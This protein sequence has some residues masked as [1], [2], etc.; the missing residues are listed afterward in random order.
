MRGALL[1]AAAVAVSL[2]VAGTAKA[3]TVEAQSKISAVTV[4][5]DGALIVRN[6][7]VKLASGPGTIVLTGIPAEAVD[8]SIRLS[9][10][11]PSK[12]RFFGIRVKRAFTPEAVEARTKEILAKIEEQ[13]A[14]RDDFKDKV[15]ARTAELDILK[16]L[17]KESARTQAMTGNVAGVAEG[18]KNVG[19]R[20]A[21]LLAESRKDTREMKK[22]EERIAALRQELAQVGTGSRERKAA[23]ADLELA[24]GGTVA[25]E[26]T[27]M[28]AGAGWSPVYDLKVIT[29]GKK[30]KVTLAFGAQVRQRSGEDWDGVKMTISTAKPAESGRIPDP[31]EWWIDFMPAPR[32]LYRAQRAGKMSLAMPSAAPMAMDEAEAPREA[33]EMEQAQTVRSEYA[34]SFEIV[35]AAMIPSD[36]NLHRVSIAEDTYD[37]ALSLVCVPRMAQ[38]AFIE[39]RVEYGGEQPLLPGPANVFQGD[40]FVGAIQMDPVAPGENFQIGLGKDQNV[41]VERKL[42]TQK[43]AGGGLLG[44]TKA[45]RRYNWLTTI[46]SFHE[47]TRMIEVREQLPRSRQKDIVVE[48]LDLTPDP[49]AESATQPGLKRWKLEIPS[50]GTAK[51]TFAYLVK[52]PEGSRIIGL[53]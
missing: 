16:S 12:T 36:G 34:T 29:E 42:V 13:E 4:F 6:G 41:K 40:Q 24:S 10:E 28:I 27:Y 14:K 3:A 2:I 25:F 20:I 50:K 22:S 17:T 8:S 39:A 32:P 35:R 15:E 33:V 48:P 18:T 51:V 46:K 26:L 53:E 19:T 31:T 47:G 23:E 1:G 52:F 21:Q 5:P 38:A 43:A 44:W 9:I 49:L 30:P 37:A 11:G 7:E 45:Q